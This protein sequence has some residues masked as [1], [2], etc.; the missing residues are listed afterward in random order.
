MISFNVVSLFTR[1]PIK[2]IM[3]LVGR[4]FEDILRL[5][6]HVLNTSYFSLNG[7][8]YAQI[9]GVPI[10]S[11]L[12]RVTTNFYMENFENRVLGLAPHKPL[13]W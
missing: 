4:H 6:C 11:P 3:D 8:F 13:C 10:G 2:D 12:S 5:F 1:V 9:D 7:Q